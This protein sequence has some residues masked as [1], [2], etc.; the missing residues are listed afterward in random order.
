MHCPLRNLPITF[1]EAGLVTREMQLGDFDVSYEK[2][3]AGLDLAP[4]FQGL[5]G[6]R[7]PCP[8]WGYL[9]KGRVRIVYAER[10]EV[11]TEGDCFY[12]EPGHLPIFEQ[13][14]EWVVFSPRGEHKKTAEVVR[15]NVQSRE[16]D[17]RGG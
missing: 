10:E 8:H 6:D 12:V 14:S 11:L 17:R 7:C 9:L 5:P 4:L 2:L 3:P 13:D 16:P 1:E 15:R